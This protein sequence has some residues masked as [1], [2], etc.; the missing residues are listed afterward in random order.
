MI[1][2]V[3]FRYIV[4]LTAGRKLLPN[5][6]GISTRHY[7][8][9]DQRSICIC[10]QIRQYDHSVVA[11]PSIWLITTQTMAFNNS[12]TSGICDRRNGGQWSVC[13]AAILN[14]SCPLWVKSGHPRTFEPCPLYP[15]K[16]TSLAAIVMSALCQKRTFCTAADNPPNASGFVR[17][18]CNGKINFGSV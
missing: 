2:T 18:P 13:T 7:R 15:R 11:L 17:L 6:L 12:I 4:C 9:N 1:G 3:N 10:D 5:V 16:R 8:E 14:R